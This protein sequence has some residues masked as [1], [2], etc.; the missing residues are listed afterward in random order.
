MPLG[1]AARAPSSRSCE[2]LARRAAIPYPRRMATIQATAGEPTS[3]TQKLAGS[4]TTESAYEDDDEQ[5]WI[6]PLATPIL[7][8]LRPLVVATPRER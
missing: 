6:R 8:E 2:N 1:T 4:R 7:L 5:P 3:S